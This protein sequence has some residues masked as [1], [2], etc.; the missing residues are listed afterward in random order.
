MQVYKHLLIGWGKDL[1]QD[2][3]NKIA[4]LH[5][6]STGYQWIS[7]LLNVPEST[8]GAIIHYKWKEHHSTINRPCTGDLLKIFDQGVRRLVR[9]IAQKPRTTQKDLKAAGTAVKVKIGHALHHH[10]L[11]SHLLRKAALFKKRHVEACLKFATQR[12]EKP[13]T[14]WENLVW[15]VETKSKIIPKVKFGGGLSGN[16]SFCVKIPKKNGRCQA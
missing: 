12:F 11:Y 9:R 14:Y 10:S 1:S 3:C 7:Q 5:N 8:I 15:S 16:L 13:V 6:N 2:L 4:V